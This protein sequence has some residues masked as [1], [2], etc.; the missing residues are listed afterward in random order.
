ML[1]L[2]RQSLQ[3]KIL[4]L[5]K[6]TFAVSG[7][8]AERNNSILQYYLGDYFDEN[9]DFYRAQAKKYKDAVSSFGGIEISVVRADSTNVITKKFS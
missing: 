7:K 3:R 9:S 5:I 4:T 1:P 6:Y 2:T 8:P